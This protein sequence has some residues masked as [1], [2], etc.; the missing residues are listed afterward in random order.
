MAIPG[1][2]SDH[3][4]AAPR[5]HGH[6]HQRDSSVH[7][8]DTHVPYPLADIEGWQILALVVEGRITAEQ[9]CHVNSVRIRHMR[10]ADRKKAA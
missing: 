3:E 5:R 2:I 10:A 8:G 1:E 6:Y 9:A 4:A 7:V